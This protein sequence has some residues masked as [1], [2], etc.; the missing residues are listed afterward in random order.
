MNLPSDTGKKALLF[1]VGC[2][3]QLAYRIR[4]EAESLA[5]H[6]DVTLR[7]SRFYKDSPAHESR[8]GY[9]EY[10]LPVQ[11]FH[12]GLFNCIRHVLRLT[13]C[14]KNYLRM[15]GFVLALGVV[16]L[17]LSPL[18]IVATVGVLAGRWLP[19]LSLFAAV[20]VRKT[21]TF[22]MRTIRKVR[23]VATGFFIRCPAAARRALNRLNRHPLQWLERGLKRYSRRPFSYVLLVLLK[24]LRK[25][26]AILLAPLYWFCRVA[27]FL[28][29]RSCDALAKLVVLLHRAETALSN[30]TRKRYLKALT[31]YRRW[32]YHTDAVRLIALF[33]TIFQR[34][35]AQF[36]A[37]AKEPLNYDVVYVKDL[38]VLPAAVAIR[39]A[40]GARLVYACY[41]FFP[42]SIPRF[43]PWCTASLA[44]FER[45]LVTAAERVITVTPQMADAIRK[46]YP[47]LAGK[48]SWIPN[49]DR[50]PE[51]PDMNKAMKLQDI[52]GGRRSFLYQGNFA[53]ERGIEELLQS[54]RHIDPA[55]G[56]LIIRGPHN[57]FREKYIEISKSNGTFGKGVVFTAPP[58]SKKEDLIDSI[59]AT[60]EVDAC[61]IPYLPVTINN[62]N[63]C[64]RK[65]SHYLHAG[66]M[67]I[68]NRLEFVKET[69]TKAQC[70]LVYDHKNLDNMI[71]T[72]NTCINDVALIRRCQANALAYA[73][74]EYNWEHYEEQFLHYVRG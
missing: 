43:A 65:L 61:L 39:Y 19:R 20:C 16:G 58:E 67:I 38:D 70:G 47:V 6:Y 37:W 69:I 11:P 42:H 22:L 24:I 41:E 34:S 1:L 9:E 49:V 71:E 21:L 33:R 62:K 52:I 3:P 17:V 23:S 46:S 73:R 31:G 5:R 63:C 7:G 74:N 48:V 44:W 30:A 57:A 51:M 68:S 18:I 64:P 14:R 15:A 50:I 12:K 35:F 55:A 13:A 36:D 54:W 45:C 40:C 10:R 53:D 8:P 66:R 60:R 59:I 27:C 26:P 72:F 28:I 56:V 32:F 4:I 25:A 29:G 2:E